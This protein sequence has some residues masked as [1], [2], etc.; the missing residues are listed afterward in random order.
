MHP[1]VAKLADV[2]AGGRRCRLVLVCVS[3]FLLPGALP[4]WASHIVIDGT[5]RSVAVPKRAQR[6]LSL[7]PSVTDDLFAIGSGAQVVAVSDFTRYPA[8]ATHE[9]SIGSPGSPSLEHIF[10]LHP[11]LVIGTVGINSMDTVRLLREHGIAVFMVNPIGLAG[12]YTSLEQIGAAVGR[13]Q[14]AAALVR[15]LQQRESSLRAA[16]ARRVVIRVFVPLWYDPVITIGKPAY[17]TQL[18]AV[19][20]L[21]SVTDDIAQAW[22]TISL[23]SLVQRQPDSLV[24]IDDGGMQWSRLST[25]PGWRTLRAVREHRV[26]H[27]DDRIELPS[28]VCFDALEALARQLPAAP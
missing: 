22:P 12:V 2:I 15:T 6:I 5:G 11:D 9:P 14:A 18:L 19:L 20:G 16:S 8:Q 25:L 23:E 7:A 21:E 10:S 4:L 1:L 26:L 13:A 28:P 24:L 3:V 27:V 17:I